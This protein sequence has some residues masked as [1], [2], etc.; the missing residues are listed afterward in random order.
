MP[1][2]VGFGI[3]IDGPGN[4][5]L[6]SI[7]LAVCGLWLCYDIAVFLLAKPW[8]FSWKAI[9]FCTLT[10]VTFV[11][12]ML[13]MHWLLATKLEELQAEAF[14][15]L[16]GHMVAGTDANEPIFTF[17]NGGVAEQTDMPKHQ[18]VC[19]IKIAT[20]G[21]RRAPMRPEVQFQHTDIPIQDSDVNLAHGGGDGESISCLSLV[22]A[23]ATK[24]WE[25]TCADLLL[26][27]RYVI[28]SDPINWQSKQF[29]FGT[30]LDGDH[31]E[32]FQEPVHQTANGCPSAK[33]DV[34]HYNKV[35]VCASGCTY[36]DLR[37]AVNEATCGTV[38]Y[39][40]SHREPI[41]M[42]KFKNNTCDA[43][44][45]I[46]IDAGGIPNEQLGNPH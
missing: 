3:A 13:T 17:R 14:A 4:V 6:R 20:Y 22:S 44:H 27:F 21:V 32:W 38:I 34:S 31:L 37:T 36:S 26:E 33:F 23:I 16:D 30:R 9:C 11:L 39:T 2:V 42:P 10:C 12:V 1:T 7:F 18:I 8:K 25:L 28:A 41:D 5:F 15:R 40:D 35:T 45:W 46:V 43:N 24:T 29:R 19:S